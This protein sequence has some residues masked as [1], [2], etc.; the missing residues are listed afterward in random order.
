MPRRGPIVIYQSRVAPAFGATIGNCM[1]LTLLESDRRFI[2]T[3]EC[4]A[5]SLFAHGALVWAAL[6]ATEGGRQLPLDAREARVFFL[7]PP[8]RVD[9]R[10]RQMD[11]DQWGKLGADLENGRRTMTNSPGL[12]VRRPAL[13]RRGVADKTGARGQLPFGIDFG[14]PDTVFSVLEVDSTVERFEGS[15]APAYPPELLA[16]GAEGTV[17]VQFVVDTTGLVDT[18]S[19][20]ILSSPDPQFEQSVRLALRDMQ[21]RPAK[22]SG[23]KVR[24][25]VEQHFRFTITPPRQIA[26]NGRA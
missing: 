4:A 25:L 10:S 12:F 15:A 22:R 18:T 5:I 19:V 21:F 20:R 6:A 1:R 7:L 13:G 16:K 17:Y 24:Q 9:V 8:D 3:A 14:R 23:H 2:Q 26:N 11:L